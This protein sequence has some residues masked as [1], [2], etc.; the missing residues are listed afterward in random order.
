LISVSSVN[1][2]RFFFGQFRSGGILARFAVTMNFPSMRNLYF[3]LGARCVLPGM[4]GVMAGLVLFFIGCGNS[5]RP[6]ENPF[7]PT[8]GN[9]KLARFA[10]VVYQGENPP[11]SVCVDGYT[12]PPCIGATSEIDVSG[13]AIVTNVY[14]GHTPVQAVLSSQVVVSNQGDD[15]VSLFGLTTGTPSAGG[16]IPSAVGLSSNLFPSSAPVQPTVLVGANGLVYVADSGLNAVTVVSPSSNTVVATLCVGGNSSSCTFQS[17]GA[18]PVGL[19]ATPDGTKVYVANSDNSVTVISTADNSVSRRISS[20]TTAKPVA[21]V[22]DASGD[23]IYVLENGTPSFSVIDV[24]SDTTIL[25][26]TACSSSPSPSSQALPCSGNSNFMAFDPALHRLYITNPGANSVS[27]FNASALSVAPTLLAM[28]TTPAPPS[29]PSSLAQLNGPSA[30]AVLPDGSGAYVVNGGA[31]HGCN[32][33]ADGKTFE[34]GGEVLVIN[35]SSNTISPSTGCITVGANPA[36]IAASGDGS[37]VYVPYQ[38]IPGQLAANGVTKGVTVINVSSNLIN[39][40]NSNQVVT[41]LG[42]P[43]ADPACESEN[44]PNPCNGLNRLNPVFIVS[45]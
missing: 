35:A 30:V 34:P 23:S 24:L 7:A 17:S 2:R 10:I 3:R 25:S 9:P 8:Q 26:G 37:R 40:V 27:V 36:A 14:L 41:Y 12:P 31:T 15:S 22:A 38:G 4:A 32:L 11:S 16:T 19:A 13:D 6:V 44:G 45:Q 5:Y 21:I 33:L 20:V 18:R 39:G 43:F 1:L 29:L 42:A 28:V